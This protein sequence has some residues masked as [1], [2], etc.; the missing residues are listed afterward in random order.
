MVRNPHECGS[1]AREGAEVGMLPPMRLPRRQPAPAPAGPAGTPDPA[2]PA[3]VAAP[4]AATPTA[5]PH[6]WRRRVL[7]AAGGA[8][9]VVVAVL[10]VVWFTTSIPS[11]TPLAVSTVVTD[12]TGKQLASFSDGGDRTI[13]PLSAVPPVV[14]NAVI[15]VEDRNFYNEGGISPLGIGRALLRDV[16]AGHIAQGGSTITQQYVKNAYVGKART[17]SRKLTEAVLAVKLDQKLSKNDILDRY[18]NTIYWGRGVYG[19][20]AASKAWFGKDVGQLDAN[21]AAYLAGLIREPEYADVALHPQIATRN[22]DLA[23]E[24]MVHQHHLCQADAT[25][26]AAVP[27]ASYTIPRQM[28][29]G[30]AVTG[31]AAAGSQYFASVV[32]QQLVARYGQAAVDRGGLQV[33]TTL[34]LA[35][36]Q[37]GYSAVYGFLK[38]NEPAGALVSLDG[39]AHVIAYVAGRDWATSQLDL[40]RGSAGG[41][42]GRQAGSTFKAFAL[43]AAV[44][45]GMCWHQTFAGPSVLTLPGANAG[46]DWT[47]HNFGNEN[48]GPID[49]A[50]ATANSVNTVYAQLAVQ[51][52]ADK[53]AA[54]AKAAG[55]SSPL[56]VQPSLVLGTD[57][58]S[59]LDMADAY[60][61]FANGGMHTDPSFIQSVH[62]STGKDLH[63]DTPSPTRVMQASVAQTVEALLTGVVQHGTGTA[64]AIGKPVAGKT[65][66]TENETDAWFVGFTPHVATAVWMGFPQNESTP[67]TNVRGIAVA[68]GTFPA[69]MWSNYMKAETAGMPS[70]N[71]PA[72]PAC[73]VPPPSTTS[74][75]SSSSTTSS[76]TTSSTSSTSTSVPLDTSLPPTTLPADQST[77]SSSTSSTSVPRST[78][79]SSSSTTT[80]TTVGH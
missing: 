7:L 5:A 29:T 52:G 51:V 69:Q 1:V 8:A 24:S 21:Q 30:M 15:D 33:R 26:D 18:L 2:D 78:T 31:G 32:H 22:R 49:L 40:A 70:D 73:T 41:G 37:R 67:M 79:T 23:L 75:S 58:V 54:M 9:L 80:S 68:G 53:I 11:A 66:T 71:F 47:V 25:A 27:V 19:V 3:D 35:A 20:E 76:S 12:T 6:V 48:F 34:D 44:E 28:H 38:P 17:I 63:W 56:A 43:A 61:T 60:L 36:Q 10:A 77:T 59:V 57:S 50:T 46:A 16:T 64:A 39:S 13:V 65:G 72:A 42:S 45:S 14:R 74:S 4:A 62:D 55:V